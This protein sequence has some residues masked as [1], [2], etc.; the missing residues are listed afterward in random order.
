VFFSLSKC[1]N[2]KNC[3][4][5]KVSG[6]LESDLEKSIAA[7]VLVFTLAFWWAAGGARGACCCSKSDITSSVEAGGI[8][9]EITQ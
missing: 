6:N 2:L 3:Q 5:L 7:V 9:P 8:A 4:R 1:H